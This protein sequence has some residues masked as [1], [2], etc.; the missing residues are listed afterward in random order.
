MKKEFVIKNGI[1]TKYNGTD[2]H[3]VIPDGVTTITN[4]S[5]A[6]SDDIESIVL[7][8]SVSLIKKNSFICCQKLKEI[9]MTN[10]WIKVSPE[11][12]ILCEDAYFS[13]PYGISDIGIK[14]ESLRHFVDD[15]VAGTCTPERAEAFRDYIKKSGKK[16]HNIICWYAPLT[17]YVLDENLI[18]KK[19]L[20]EIMENIDSYSPEVQ[21]VLKEYQEKQG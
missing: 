11:A 1:L 18:S 4:T 12:F 19:N 7:P 14:F 21:E 10:P 6:E 13:M 5:F 8:E 9:T 20:K 16:L 15:Y 17:R 2:T 3:V